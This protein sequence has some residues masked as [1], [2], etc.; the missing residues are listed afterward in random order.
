MKVWGEGKGFTLI[1]LLVVIAIITIL[2][3]IL[4]PALNEARE[5][6]R[7]ASCKNNLKQIGMA[8]F[9]YAQADKIMLPPAYYA[10]RGFFTTRL[11][12]QGYI[13]DIRTAWCPS[14]GRGE[15]DGIP[16]NTKNGT[17]YS[18]VKL[19]RVNGTSLER[20]DVNGDNQIG[21]WSPSGGWVESIPFFL[22]QKYGASRLALVSDAPAHPNNTSRGY[23]IIDF[24][25]TYP[26]NGASIDRAIRHS[27]GLNILFYDQHVK[28]H[29]YEDVRLNRE[30]YAIVP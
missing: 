7:Q 29:R 30:F 6:A 25:A 13:N 5:K 17:A 1:E 9:M 19:T 16:L 2:A 22:V 12:N 26:P 14:W 28:W 27:G 4:L 15:Y 23:E 24:F 8:L 21:G 20:F 11:Y 3:A 10:G 18:L